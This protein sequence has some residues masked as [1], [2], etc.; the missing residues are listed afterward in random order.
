[1]VSNIRTTEEEATISYDG[2]DGEPGRIEIHNSSLNEFGFRCEV[3]SR[4]V[5]GSLDMDIVPI[6]FLN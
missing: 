3:S 2:R 1:M 5:D 6:R 4:E